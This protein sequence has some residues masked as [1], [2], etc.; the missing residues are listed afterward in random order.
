[1]ERRAARVALITCVLLLAALT[2]VLA[3]LSQDAIHVANAQVPDP[4]DLPVPPPDLCEEEPSASAS[5]SGSAS[6]SPS[7]SA[8]SSPSTSPSPTT[9]PSGR[10]CPSPSSSSSPSSSPSPTPC[11]S[12]SASRSPSTTASSS[13]SGSP[14]QQPRTISLFASKN[15]VTSGDEVD[16]EGQIFSAGSGCS[17][18]DEFVRLLR[19]PAGSD[20][21]ENFLSELTGEDGRYRFAGVRIERNADYK[22]LAPSHD[23]CAAAESSTVTV[24]ARA[25]VSIAANDKTP[26]RG[27]TVR[28]FGRVSP[29]DPN[30]KVR[31][32]QRRGGGWET[33]LGDRLNRRSRYV[34]VFEATGPKTQRYRVHWLGSNENEPGTSREL[35]LK[36]HK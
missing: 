6:S 3:A 27:S 36:L 7:A 26:E 8:S 24:T 12:Q 11:P 21:F 34:F 4:C 17:G 30:S 13:P 9:S 33:V 18:R 25:R 2:P 14:A 20:T 10:S 28:I 31:L 16:F 32:Q 35:T 19:R 22:A 1:M 23:S 15:E 5:A 29:G